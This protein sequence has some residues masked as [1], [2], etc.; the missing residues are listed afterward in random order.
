VTRAKVS[1]VGPVRLTNLLKIAP[2]WIAALML[3][4]IVLIVLIGP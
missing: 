4:A 2:Q 3:P 1:G